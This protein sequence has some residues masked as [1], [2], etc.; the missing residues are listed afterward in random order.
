MHPLK[1]HIITFLKTQYLNS[2][3]W[4][5]ISMYIIEKQNLGV[6]MPDDVYSDLGK[7]VKELIKEGTIEEINKNLYKLIWEEKD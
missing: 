2:G 1:Q 7:A 4:Y 5:R 3:S 6:F